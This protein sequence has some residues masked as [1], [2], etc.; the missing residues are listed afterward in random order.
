M[1]AARVC[2]LEPVAMGPAGASPLARSRPP[3]QT[4]EMLA[5]L[6]PDRF[7]LIL[8]ATILFATLLPA[9]GVGLDIAGH[10]SNAAIFSLFFF[11]GLRLERSAVWAGLTHWRLQLAILG[12][13]FVAL[14]LLA[15]AF[16]GLIPAALPP[17]LWAGVFFLSAL[18]STV[19]A[20]IA[21]TSMA[22]GNVAASVVAAAISNLSAV[23]LTPLILAA[24]LSI[25]AGGTDLSAIGRIAALLLLPFALGQIARAWLAG[26]AERNRAWIGRLDRLTIVLAIYVAF[27]AAVNE[28]LWSRLSSETLFVVTELMVAML[29]LAFAASWSLGAALGLPREDRLALFFAGAHKSLATGAPMARIL[30]PA[31]QAG[32]IVI[33]LMIYHQLQ[34]MVSA[35]VAARWGRIT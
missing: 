33:P 31:A 28:G 8:L 34:L 17:E 30:F 10:V 21:S 11:H 12:C 18:P 25:G 27:S 3:R 15:L 16:N 13:T 9:S 1:N 6:F 22:K 24:M 20:A 32:L 5:R 29:A 26:W 7:V 4:A 2:F 19:Q 23:V 35:W 14:P